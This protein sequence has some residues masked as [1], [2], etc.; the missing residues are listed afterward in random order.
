MNDN[1]SEKYQKLSQREHILLK[2]GMYVGDIELREDDLWILDNEKIILKKISWSPGFYKTFDE[3]LVNAYDQSIRDSTMTNININIEPNKI[4]IFNDGTG[5]DIEKHPKYKI[6]IPEL[7]FGHLLT[8]TNYNPNQKRITGGTH[9]LGAKLTAIFSTKFQI[10]VWDKKRKLFY[11]QTFINNLK[12]IN[13]PIIKK[14]DGEKGGVKITWYPDFKRFN[15]KEIDTEQLKLL[16]RRSYDLIG[17]APAIKLTL[18]NTK[19][20][21]YGWDNYINLYSPQ[22]TL[23]FNCGT[24]WQVTIALN[25]AGSGDVISFVNG[26]NTIRG[27]KH[28]DYIWSLLLPNIKKYLKGTIKDRILKDHIKLFVKTN[29]V[30][31]SFSSQTKESLMT[32]INKLF[33]CSIPSIFWKKFK[34]NKNDLFNELIAVI[35][36][37]NLVLLSKT[38]SSKKRKLKGI[39]KL[40]DANWAG[41][42]KSRRCTLILTEGD[43]AKATA[44]S[45]ISAIKDGRNIFG[46]FPLRG[47]LLNV[48]EASINQITNNQEITDLKKIMGFKTDITYSAEN[49]DKLRYGSILLM[50]DAD[51]DGSHIKGLV[52]NFLHHFFP[53]LLAIPDFLKVLVT[54]I[55]KATKKNNVVSFPNLKEYNKWKQKVDINNWKIKYYKGLGTST[56]KEAG[57]YFTNYDDNIL[58]IKD[59]IKKDVHPDLT[60]AFSKL[61]ADKRKEWLANYDETNVVHFTPNLSISINDFINKELIHFSHYDNLRSIPKLGDGFKPS[62]R[63]VL[64]ACFKKNLKQE[65]KVAQLSGYVAEQTSYHHGENSLVQT[66]INMAQNF[67]GSNNLNLLVPQGQFGTRLLGGKDHSSARYIFTF[68][69]NITSKIFLSDDNNILQFLEDDGFKIE[70]SVYYPIIPMILVNGAEGIGTGYSTYL[71]PYNPIKIINWVINKID[72]NSLPKLKPWFNNF[73]G[74]IKQ[75]NNKNFISIGSYEINADKLI[76]TELPIKLWTSNYK[77][78]IEKLVWD[79]ESGFSSYT[80]ESTEKEVK[81][82]L[83]I[84]NMD[85]ILKLQNQ[86]DEYGLNYLAKYLKLHKTVKLTNIHLFNTNNQ[87]QLYESVEQIINEFY[88]WRLVLYEKRK[89]YLLYKLKYDILYLKAKINWISNINNNKINLIKMTDEQIINYLEKNKVIQKNKSWDYLLKL[90][91]SSLS[92]STVEKLNNDLNELN[93]EF[94]KLKK[95]TPVQIWKNDLNNLLHLLQK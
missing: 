88:N 93:S 50:M 66:I 1:I 37:T 28:V 3:I 82:T 60:L 25:K 91:L 61:A 68:L 36:Q 41:T 24:N 58:M 81:F 26:I 62:S 39:P 72:G 89:K 23:G 31:P 95:R 10:E 32:P 8:S 92:K 74:E 80:N 4:E 43:S 73:K 90:P 85:K 44:I 75:I 27:G 30:N 7:I 48:R 79:K 70:P 22:N 84:N 59:D 64:Y 53:S 17:I 12:I 69:S 14:Y 67:V 29:V 20:E 87:I 45:G 76:I 47:K 52:I 2:P 55:I 83:K 19:I 63:K 21:N 77:E 51:V 78:F 15:M 13:K 9:G 46:V 65:F 5:I 16:N 71:P 54:P 57:E 86:I 40:D 38:D 11:T 6:Y 56:S 18:N 34:N 49:L 33:P 42:T 94:N 35:K